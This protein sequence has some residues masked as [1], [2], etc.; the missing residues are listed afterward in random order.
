MRTAIF[1]PPL[2]RP[3]GGVAVLT[4]LAR[5]LVAQGRDAI[6][7][8]PE[9]GHVP[10][11]LPTAPFDA[12]G[13]F[14]RAG[15]VLVVPEGWPG[16]I[17]TGMSRKARVL[18]YVQ[19]WSFMQ[20]VLPEGVAWNR[21]PVE[22]LA[23]SGPVAWFLENVLGLTV[24]GVVPA[25]VDPV[26]F[27]RRG[28]R[29]KGMR[30]AWMP[31]KNKGLA[32]QVQRIASE[33]LERAAL[34]P[35]TFVPIQGLPLEGVAEILAGCQV[36]QCSGFP[37]GFALPPLE[38]MACGCVPTGFSGIGG[39][40]Y[41]RNPAPPPPGC[42]TP[43]FTLADV[44]WSSGNGLFAADGDVLGAGMLLARAVGWAVGGAPQWE[45]LAGNGPMTAEAYGPERM[46]A[47]VEAVWGRLEGEAP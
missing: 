37:E 35:A 12:N 27:G 3:S 38:A 11:D 22:H 39:F 26:F 19:N 31:R 23:V 4:Q 33:L 44:P 43:P 18:V 29:G 46:E 9:S 41:M 2:K 7:T 16:I 36:F 21:L 10:R 8:C 13:D 25:V 24:L 17:P 20:G 15:D 32:R 6:L 1:I 47:A 45:T 40:E 30:V 28:E 5:T 34:P 14:L 42:W